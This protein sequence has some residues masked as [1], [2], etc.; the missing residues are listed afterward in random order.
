[1]QAR[2]ANDLRAETAPPSSERPTI[3]APAYAACRAS[4]MRAQVAYEMLLEDRLAA[5]NASASARPTLPAPSG[6]V[7]LELDW[8]AA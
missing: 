6:D 5:L 7:E 8:S 3:P 4:A 1:V 2:I